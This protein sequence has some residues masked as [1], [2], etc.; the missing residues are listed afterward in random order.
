MTH[1]S[2]EIHPYPGLPHPR[3]RARAA[4]RALG[5]LWILASV[6]GMMLPGRLV[7]AD[8]VNNDG[9]AHAAAFAAGVALW[10]VAL[11]SRAAVV[12]A[13]ALALALGSELAQAVLLAGRDA[14]WLDVAAD[15][16]GIVL[17]LGLGLAASA[18][19]AGWERWAP[20]ER[21]L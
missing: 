18:A 6:V 5:V 15:G 17:G 7:P 3:S 1:P 12:A 13:V 10:V 16:V 11:P 2:S 14:Q 9:I 8:I 21:R 4:C 19:V 20:S